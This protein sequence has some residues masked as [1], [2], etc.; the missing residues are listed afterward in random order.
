[1]TSAEFLLE[2]APRQPVPHAAFRYCSLRH[3]KRYGNP[4]NEASLISLSC[5]TYLR[6]VLQILNDDDKK[7]KNLERGNKRTE[8]K[9][10]LARA[11]KQATTTVC[12]LSNKIR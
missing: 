10:F 12:P 4:Y 5:Q 9:V 6:K 7:E 8:E 3:G 2:T 11:A 1:M